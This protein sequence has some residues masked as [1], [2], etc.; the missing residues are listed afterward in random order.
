MVLEDLWIVLVFSIP[1]MLVLGLV[2][3][4]NHTTYKLAK[5]A[6]LQSYP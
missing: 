4:Q 3:R 5:D 6:M 1:F 2:G